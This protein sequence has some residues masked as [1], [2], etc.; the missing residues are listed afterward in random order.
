MNEQFIFE[1]IQV[2]PC[3]VEQTTTIRN[4][5]KLGRTVGQTIYH[6][7]ITPINKPTKRRH[8]TK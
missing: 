3:M 8:K 1:L 4:P 2:K 7:P 6:K 5:L